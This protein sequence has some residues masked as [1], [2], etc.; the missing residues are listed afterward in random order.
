V[1]QAWIVNAS[2]QQASIYQMATQLQLGNSCRCTYWSQQ[3]P[4]GGRRDKTVAS[5]LYKKY[6]PCL[7]RVGSLH[8]TRHALRRLNFYSFTR[9]EREIREVLAVKDWGSSR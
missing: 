2:Q 8:D 3:K 4:T 6:F 9:K 5:T 7:D 1:M